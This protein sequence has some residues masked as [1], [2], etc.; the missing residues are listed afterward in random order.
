MRWWDGIIDSR[1]MSLSNLW[2]RIKDR[3][4][5]YSAVHGVKNSRTRLS[6]RTTTKEA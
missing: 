4:D 6:D 5:W 1:D 2:E 3:K